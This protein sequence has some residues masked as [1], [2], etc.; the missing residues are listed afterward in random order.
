MQKTLIVIKPEATARW[1]TW[2]IIGRLEKAGL[3]MISGKY[4]I[5]SKE[6]LDLH[7]P[8]SRTEWITSLGQRTDEWYAELWLD[9]MAGFGTTDHFQIGLEVRN[10]LSIAMSSG[11]TFAAVLEWDNAVAMV[12]KIIGS[13][14]PEKALPGTIRWDYSI[15]TVAAANINKRPINNLIHAS[16][17][18][19]ESDYEVK[20]RFPEIA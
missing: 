1:L 16:G 4:G 18:Q 14:I 6:I 12:R 17:N 19:E 13:T 5:A 9:L 15:D 11:F 2:E 7:Y 3:K 10:R 20:L 8:A